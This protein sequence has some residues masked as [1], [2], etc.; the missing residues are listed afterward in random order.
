[1]S[2]E[3]R[4]P[5]NAIIG[6]TDILSESITSPADKNYLHAIQTSSKSLL[7]LIN[8]IL[9]LSK[10]EAGKLDLD[11]TPVNPRAVFREMSEI[12]SQKIKKKQLE[13]ILDL[14]P[15]LP[16]AFKLDETRLRQILL[17][18]VGNAVKFTESGHVKLNASCTYPKPDRK[19]ANLM[20]AV[21]DTGIGIPEDQQNTIFGAFSQQLGQN[22]EKYGGTGLGLAITKRLVEAMNGKI[23]VA[24]MPDKGSVFVIEFFNLEVASTYEQTEKESPAKPGSLKFKP[25]TPPDRGR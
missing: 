15:E 25:A 11:Y 24:S 16:E 3:I 20:I 17:N 2:H 1:M 21:E 8:D 12:F 7:T 5:L 18:L 19:T 6:F 4:T 13:F 23:S 10:V 9:D 22:R 14:S